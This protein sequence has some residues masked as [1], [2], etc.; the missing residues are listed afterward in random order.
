[1]HEL[2]IAMSIVDMAEEEAR[3]RNAKIAAV[4]L[5]LGLLSGV[6]KDALLSCYGMACTGTPLEGSKLLIEEVPVEIFCAACQAPRVLSSMQWF[7]CPE[8][9]TPSAAVVHGKELEVS[10]LEI[11]Q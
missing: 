11:E 6:V 5:R 7:C 1:M 2:S 3:M 9:G 4:H 10:A 8:C